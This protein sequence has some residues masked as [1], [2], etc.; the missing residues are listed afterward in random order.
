MKK[1]LMCF[2][3]KKNLLCFVWVL[4]FAISGSAADL[5]TLGGG[6][7]FVPKRL[8]SQ[9]EACGLKVNLL[10]SSKLAGFGGA[11]TKINPGNADEPEPPKADGIT[12]EFA[13]LDN[14]KAVMFHN[15]PAD[16]IK[17]MLTPERI[18][19]LK[20]YVSN[21]GALILNRYAPETL[22]DLLPVKFTGGIQ[23]KIKDISVTRP[24]DASFSFLPE[25]WNKLS[26]FRL[27][28]AVPGAEVLSKIIDKNGDTIAVGVAKMQYGKGTVWFY[29]SDWIR[30]AGQKQFWS[31]AYGRAFMTALVS[32]ATGTPVNIKKAI[33]STPVAPP[34]KTY[35]E[36]SIKVVEPVN[37]I[38]LCKSVKASEHLIT[39]AN[40]TQLF[41]RPDG[42][43]EVRFPGTKSDKLKFRPPFVRVSDTP[44]VVTG[45]E[46]IIEKSNTKRYKI[47]WEMTGFKVKGDRLEISYAGSDGSAIRWVFRAG[48]MTLDGRK[49]VGIA[50]NVIVDKMPILL[51]SLEFKATFPASFIRRTAVYSSPRGYLEGFLSN[52]RKDGI[53]NIGRWQMFCGGQP[54]VYNKLK[55]GI[56]VEFPDSPVS[57]YVEQKA[58]KTADGSERTLRYVL[59]RLQAPQNL[60]AMWHFYAPG[61]ERGNNDFM[62]T[63]QFVRKHLKNQFGIKTFAMRTCATAYLHGITPEA[64]E[65]IMQAAQKYNFK[66]FYFMF[67]QCRLANVASDRAANFY[68]LAKKYGMA[69]HPWTPG[70]A[71]SWHDTAYTEHPEFYLKDIKGKTQSYGKKRPIVDFNN[72]DFREWYFKLMD[73]AIANGM[74]ELYVDM[75]GQ[76]SSNV[77]YAGKSAAPNLEGVIKVFKYWS[78]KNIPFAIE[79]MNP[80]GRDQALFNANKD[81]NVTGKEF[82]YVGGSPLTSGD[83]PA[84][85]FVY[86]RLLMHNATTNIH[87]DGVSN[88]FDRF[89]N[90]CEQFE[91]IGKVNKIMNKAFE[92]VPDPWVRE[93]P[94]GTMWMGKETGALFFYDQ[95]K[96]LDLA[97]PAGWQVVKG[98]KLTDIPGDS[99][100]FIEKIK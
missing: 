7:P 14:Y 81:A 32:A 51:N 43:I 67:G 44:E 76:A 88:D 19:A 8:K 60:A 68:A 82:A 69:T 70:Y 38:T 11:S 52:T 15:I 36:L 73:Q 83:R 71:D 53:K 97:L 13:R 99:A 17:K 94:C 95:V 5:L 63:W 45:N 57:C 61:E 33:D 28:K 39:F 25:K 79:G 22:G 3:M 78:D 27:S 80:L 18:D 4:A 92:F 85:N 37:G 55:S 62:A 75:M 6:R 87:V 48:D 29:N 77:N 89:P 66:S 31:W 24:N 35:D 34:K 23:T 56:V 9:M 49:F 98:S 30:Y 16:L 1:N 72:P 64:V 41:I 84:I 21:G 2:V 86:F 93:T 42:I 20:K 12:P 40:K 26:A 100:I 90:E 58:Y 59:G 46:A 91:Y 65:K 74:D 54:F 47:S 50:D 96:K 10:D